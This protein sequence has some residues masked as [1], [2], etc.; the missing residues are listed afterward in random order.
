MC[1]LFVAIFL[2]RRIHSTFLPEGVGLHVWKF[3]DSMCENHGRST[4]KLTNPTNTKVIYTYCMKQLIH[5]ISLKQMS[6][7]KS[8]CPGTSALEG[9]HGEVSKKGLWKQNN[10]TMGGIH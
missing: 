2:I 4:R 3:W 10:G 9:V 7:E 6:V 5:S 8:G 1:F